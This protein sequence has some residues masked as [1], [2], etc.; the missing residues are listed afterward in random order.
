MGPRLIA[1]GLRRRRDRMVQPGSSPGR[2]KRGLL[3]FDGVGIEDV[4]IAKE[5]GER[6]VGA[7]V[8]TEQDIAQRCLRFRS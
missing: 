7:I 6:E 3:E 1:L 5:R 2:A 4:V 8:Q